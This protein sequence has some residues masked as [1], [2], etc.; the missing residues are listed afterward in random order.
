MYIYDSISLNLLEWEMFQTNVAEKIET[1]ILCSIHFLQKLCRL[2]DTMEK[3]GTAREATG[4]NIMY[5][6]CF[7]YQIT[8]VKI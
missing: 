8:D 7:A 3:Y 2:W 5:R 6:I 1:H 4:D